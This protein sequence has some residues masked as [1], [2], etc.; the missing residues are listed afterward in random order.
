MYLTSACNNCTFET[1]E[2]NTKRPYLNEDGLKMLKTRSLD[3]L[4]VLCANCCD[5]TVG[6]SIQCGD[7]IYGPLVNKQY[8]VKY[9][10]KKWCNLYKVQRAKKFEIVKNTEENINK[11]N[12]DKIELSCLA[13]FK[14]KHGNGRLYFFSNVE[15][16]I[17]QTS[18]Y[19]TQLG[20]S[21]LKGR[22]DSYLYVRD[23]GKFGPNQCNPYKIIPRYW[24]TE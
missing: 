4:K 2:F 8:K 20:E 14:F 13:W 16:N 7:I 18:I 24:V 19:W 15:Q 21:Y 11:A 10:N 1:F 23:S 6:N 22:R 9:N 3:V 5:E 17:C 12:R